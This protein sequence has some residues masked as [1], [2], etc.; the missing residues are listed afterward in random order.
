MCPAVCA[1]KPA[2]T[3]RSHFKVFV[4]LSELVNIA[5]LG[6]PPLLF[7]HSESLRRRLRGQ[8]SRVLTEAFDSPRFRS[9]ERAG[10]SCGWPT[11]DSQPSARLC[12]KLP[13]SSMFGRP[14]L[15]HLQGCCKPCC[16]AGIDAGIGPAWEPKRLAGSR[17]IGMFLGSPHPCSIPHSISAQSATAAGPGLRSRL[18][19]DGEKRP[20]PHVTPFK[21]LVRERGCVNIP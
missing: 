14:W 20:S 16:G 11:S 17:D 1:R 18:R 3:A 7:P 19:R 4:F 15:V 9:D 10:G 13:S 5:F 2:N 8:R 6:T 12:W 21:S